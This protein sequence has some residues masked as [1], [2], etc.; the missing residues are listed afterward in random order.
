M[1]HALS[2]H[3]SLFPDDLLVPT[4]TGLQPPPAREIARL[5]AAAIELAPVSR[6]QPQEIAIAE[7]R[8]G[9]AGCKIGVRRPR[10]RRVNWAMS[11]GALCDP[12]TS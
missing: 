11:S 2:R 8:H 12:V 9:F 3:R 4:H 5:I 7:R 10:R 6:K 1:C